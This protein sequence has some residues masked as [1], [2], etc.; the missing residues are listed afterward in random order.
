MTG[1]IADQSAER[2]FVVSDSFLKGRE[3][4]QARCQVLAIN[5]I[6]ISWLG[7]ARRGVTRIVLATTGRPPYASALTAPATA[8]AV[9]M[10]VTYRTSSTTLSSVAPYCASTFLAFASHRRH[11]E[12]W[13]HRRDLPWRTRVRR[14]VAPPSQDDCRSG[15]A[16][17]HPRRGARHRLP[18][19]RRARACRRDLC[20]QLT[21]PPRS[22]RYRR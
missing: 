8:K 10:S 4:V 6:S 19:L 11:A 5:L 20:H 18:C 13:V 21:S 9:S 1:Q 7:N 12:E 17:V 15:T 16:S 22:G 14:A 2:K 3:C